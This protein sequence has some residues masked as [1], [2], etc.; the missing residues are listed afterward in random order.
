MKT[1]TILTIILIVLAI[2]VAIPLIIALFVKKEYAIEKEVPVNS[3]NAIVF[4]YIKQI[5]NQR[6]YSVWVM[7]DPNLK[8]E[9]TGID[10]TIGFVSY[11]NGN[12]KAGEGEQEITN[13][14][15][16]KRVDVEIR[17]KRPFKST[18]TT[19]M[20]VEAINANSTRVRCEMRGKSSYPMNFMNLFMGNMLGKDMDKSLQ[21]LKQI[22]EKQ[23]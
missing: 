17:F 5:K 4:E 18:A 20:A 11:W 8:Q 10:G 13:I 14:D 21:N 6:N 15:E 1:M 12:N 3:P 9:F 22:I 2:I 16:G 23:H 7:A 19:Y